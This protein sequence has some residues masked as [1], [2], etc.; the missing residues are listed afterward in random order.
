LA[1]DLGTQ[2]CWDGEDRLLLA[3]RGKQSFDIVRV[4]TDGGGPV[5][6]QGACNPLCDEVSP[7]RSG[8]DRLFSRVEAVRM[9]YPMQGREYTPVA[10]VLRIE[11]NGVPKTVHPDAALHRG[12]LSVR[13][14]DAIEYSMRLADPLHF[15]HLYS[16][17]RGL[18]ASPTGDLV[19]GR[20]LTLGDQADHGQRKTW[21]YSL[22]DLWLANLR[23]G[24]LHALTVDDATDEMDPRFSPDGDWVAYAARPTDGSGGAQTSVYVTGLTG[25]PALRIGDGHSPRWSPTSPGRLWFVRGGRLRWVALTTPPP[26][27]RPLSGSVLFTAGAVLAATLLIA[28]TWAGMRLVPRWRARASTYLTTLQMAAQPRMQSLAMAELVARCRAVRRSIHSYCNHTTPRWFEDENGCRDPVRT[29]DAML[30]EDNLAGARA[31]AEAIDAC[32]QSFSAHSVTDQ[33]VLA[34]LSRPLADAFG[35]AIR[36]VMALGPKLAGAQTELVD[37]AREYQRASREGAPPGADL[38]AAALARMEQ[39]ADTLRCPTGPGVLH[40]LDETLDRLSVAGLL[41]RVAVQSAARAQAAH[42][43]ITL[44]TIGHLCYLPGDPETLRQLVGDAIDNSLKAIELRRTRQP[45]LRGQVVLSM[46]DDGGRTVVRVSDNGAG[47]A[48][49]EVARL[50]RGERLDTAAPGHGLGFSIGLETARGYPGGTLRISSGGRDTG[51]VVEI[52]ID[53]QRD[54]DAQ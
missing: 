32:M 42:T 21:Q 31:Y 9:P 37:L 51:A 35:R 4:A 25:G 10:S 11:G 38:C 12:L 15:H 48:K 52:G 40:L 23:T 20:L 34:S 49:D 43:D 26:P 36:A 33:A 2:L 22:D 19:A 1:G 13:V 47:L 14:A 17:F 5:P 50:N 29:L 28:G 16:S 6:L 46:G 39:R 18:V 41:Q 8:P 44:G 7:V 54:G 53:M 24:E 27:N 45:D 3:S 30:S